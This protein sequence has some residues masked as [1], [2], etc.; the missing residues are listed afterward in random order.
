M[1]AT[2]KKPEEI[3]VLR[4]GGR[5]LARIMQEVAR[6]VKPG[7]S[8]AALDEL[9]EKLARDGGDVPILLGYKPWSAKRAFPASICISVNNEVVHGIP[10]EDPHILKEGDILSLD[11]CLEHGGLITDMA[12]SVGV[13]IIDEKAERLFK[14][15]R[16][17]RDLGIAAAR[18]G[19]HVGDIGFAIDAVAQKYGYGNVYELGGHGVGYK[20][21]EEPYIMNVG[22]VG[23]G[24]ELVPGMVIAI[25]PMFT[26]GDE[27]V[28]LLADG[29]TYVT[30]DGS[31]AAHFEHSVLVTDGAPEILTKQ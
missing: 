20:V 10:N 26:E 13:G 18:G 8:T 22:E 17:A 4:E 24:E 1:K 30:K 19:A 14:A 27:R 6:A 2:I 11:M 31:R 12:L 15:T 9:A 16:E 21:H 3:P 7:I 29:Y 23:K 28:K 5:R 25:E